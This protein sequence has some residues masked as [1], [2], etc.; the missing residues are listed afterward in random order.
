MRTVI[1]VIIV[2]AI[3]F[4]FATLGV[5]VMASQPYAVPTMSTDIAENEMQ[6]IPPQRNSNSQSDVI[7]ADEIRQN[8]RRTR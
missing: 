8:A 4:S 7:S 1:S 3:L 2:W 6:R 5:K